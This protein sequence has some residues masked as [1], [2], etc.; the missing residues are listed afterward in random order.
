MILL[1]KNGEKNKK[2]ITALSFAAVLIFAVCFWKIMI[3]FLFCFVVA[4]M[5]RKIVKFIENVTGMNSKISGGICI[6]VCY[7][8]LFGATYIL[9]Q[10]FVSEI[11]RLA[12]NLPTIY[13]TKIVPL[14]NSLEKGVF[15]LFGGNTE[16]EKMIKAFLSGA[17]EQSFRFL[18]NLS[19]KVTEIVAKFVLNLP[20]F[21]V[22]ATVTI[23]ASFFICIDYEKIRDFILLQFSEDLKEKFLEIKEI[24]YKI[25]FKIIYS[26]FL[27]FLLTFSQLV[28]GLLLLKVNYALTLSLI[29]AVADIFPIIGT[30]TILV[31][32]AIFEF[33]NVNYPL[34]IGLIALFFIITVVRNIVEPKI[35]GKNIGIHP[36]LS[37][38]AMYFGLKTGGVIWAVFLPILLGVI[39]QLNDN[40]IIKLYKKKDK[41]YNI[42]A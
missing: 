41:A 9:A 13:N 31:P 11:I 27:I 30:G 21:F 26:Y 42:N 19:N 39:K 2:L 1:N 40:G 24:F 7:A 32:W 15:Q 4:I 33:V 28:L 23:I 3:P 20:D 22:T 36:L 12:E 14:I 37:L 10:S 8:L 25:I 34:A 5:L 35:I 17:D 38:A 29:I 16:F 6:T 18:I